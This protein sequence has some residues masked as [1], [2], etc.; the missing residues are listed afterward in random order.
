MS[1]T[2]RQEMRVDRIATVSGAR[3]ASSARDPAECGADNKAQESGRRLVARR[4]RGEWHLASCHANVYIFA[5]PMSL[6]PAK[7]APE[8]CSRAPRSAQTTP[9]ASSSA[10]LETR[11]RSGM[12]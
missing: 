2:D 10:S 4:P 12:S 1:G 8:H 3:P 6:T 9:F 5:R 11:P 7:R